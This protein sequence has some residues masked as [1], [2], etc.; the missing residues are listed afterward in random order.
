MEGPATETMK[1]TPGETTAAM[2]A[3]SS[4]AALSK[5]E[6]RPRIKHHSRDD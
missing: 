2:K 4:A 1:T 6:L 3:T 5:G